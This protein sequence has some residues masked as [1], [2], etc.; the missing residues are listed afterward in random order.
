MRRRDQRQTGSARSAKPTKMESLWATR[1]RVQPG[2]LPWDL[3]MPDVRKPTNRELRR[4][5]GAAL[6]TQKSS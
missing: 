1:G 4:S 3:S 5:F 6:G 2:P